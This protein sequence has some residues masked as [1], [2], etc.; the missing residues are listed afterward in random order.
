LKN[1]VDEE[2][3]QAVVSYDTDYLAH[4][5]VRVSNELRKQVYLSAHLVFALSGSGMALQTSRAE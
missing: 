4:G 3:E 2:T 5:Q 1:R